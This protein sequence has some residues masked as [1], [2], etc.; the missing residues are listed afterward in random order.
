MKKAGAVLSMVAAALSLSACALRPGD[1]RYLV[2][3]PGARPLVVETAS[4]A[5]RGVAAPEGQAFLAI[6][7]AAPPVGALRFKPP[8]PAAPW[9]GVRDAT[10]PGPMCMQRSILGAGPRSEDCLTLNVYAPRDADP[11]RPRPVMVWI[12]GGGFAIG[13]NVQ[14]DPS[15]IAER[16]GVVVV[17]PNYRL[18]A[19][20]FLAHPALSG[21]GEGAY[22]LLD[23]QAA[24]RWVQSNIARFG[25]DPRNVTLF[26]E[27]AGGWSVCY[28]LAAPGARGLFQHAIIESGACTSP[29]SA[30]SM[31]SAEA[32][33]L[34]FAAALGC[35]DLAA[36]A[37]CLRR[38]PAEALLKAKAERRGLLGVNSW[39]P[40]YD[41]DVLPLSPKAAFQ[42]GRFAS[43][44]VID[45]TNHDEGRL[46]L[47][48]NRLMGKLWTEASYE[49][50]VHD[51]FEENT[52]TVLAEYAE[53]AKRD[54]GLAYADIV[55]DSTFSC[56][57]LTLNALLRR[58]TTG[59]A[60]VYAYEFDDPKA[61]FDLPR[62]PFIPPLKA[63]H[64]SE[65]VY[66]MQTPWAL[67]NPVH[68]DS[69]QRALSDRMQ[70]Y[71]GA[72]ARTG[73]PNGAGAIAWP[74]D[75]GAAPLTLSPGGVQPDASFSS[76]HRCAFW[77]ALGY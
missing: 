18:G 28:Q 73:D 59:H 76:R 21:P 40:A 44:P 12:Y 27:S 71:W 30:I 3:A 4:G 14:Y 50:I 2:T 41:G 75:D 47:Y 20:G 10:K 22:A 51:F 13:D 11:A 15:R 9:S 5:V 42:E 43:V 8:E 19:F 23:Q 53:E 33:G 57:A 46:F 72:F 62:P 65:I 60:P 34:Q 58:R 56:P 16:Q 32:G 39:A 25:G 63:Y 64:S 37:D 35:G 70:A 55:T 6:P 24:L 45:G 26:G 52:P 38:L 17:A 7:F 66:V 74:T 69:A 48:T 1:V 31:A 36:T 49:A 54:R 77:N 61:L 67:A 68:F 29:D